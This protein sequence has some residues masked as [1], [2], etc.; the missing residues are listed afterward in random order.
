MTRNQ[1]HLFWSYTEKRLTETKS[2]NKN[3][4]R[5]PFRHSHSLLDQKVNNVL[6]VS[7]DQI[8][9]ASVQSIIQNMLASED[10]SQQ[11]LHFLQSCGFGGL[12]RFAGPFTKV[13]FARAA[14]SCWPLACT[15][16]EPNCHLVLKKG[17]EGLL[18]H[19]HNCIIFFPL[20]TT[21]WSNLPSCLSTVWR[22]WS[23]RVCRWR[24]P[25]RCRRHRDPTTWARAWAAWRWDHRRTKVLPPTK[26]SPASCCVVVLSLP[27]CTVV[28]YKSSSIS[29]LPFACSY[30]SLLQLEEITFAELCSMFS[31]WLWFKPFCDARVT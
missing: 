23:R 7:N 5:L 6:S 11:P 2:T 10:A 16:L 3:I 18:W 26:P 8:V 30:T 14:D 20:S 19:F 9:L 27:L 22:R 13:S 29:V 1:S 25:L 15:S 17:V 21:W 28:T 4:C 24:K 31:H 12:W